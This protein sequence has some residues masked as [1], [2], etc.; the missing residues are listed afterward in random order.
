MWIDF[1]T[2]LVHGRIRNRPAHVRDF[3]EVNN[4]LVMGVMELRRVRPADTLMSACR[5][6]ASSYA[7]M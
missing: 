1:L 2:F 6:Q 3:G 4:A 7:F 5:T